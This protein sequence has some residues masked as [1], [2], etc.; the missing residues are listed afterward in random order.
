DEALQEYETILELDPGLKAA[1]NQLGYLYAERGDFATGL[2]FMD[3]YQELAADEPNPYDSRGEI[4]MFSGRFEEAVEQFK[5]ALSKRPDFMNSIKGLRQAYGELDD[6]ENAMKFADRAINSAASEYTQALT[7]VDQALLSWRFDRIL[8]AQE[9]LKKAQQ[10]FPALV[11]PALIGGEMYRSIGDRAAAQQLQRKYLNW[12]RRTKLNTEID[13]E[14]LY[15]MLHFSLEAD[16]PPEELLPVVETITAGETRGMQ[17]QLYDIYLS[18]LNIRAGN[19]SQARTY[20]KS[21]NEIFLNLLT[22]VRPSPRNDSWKYSIEA[23]R[24]LPPE[25]TP[26]YTY[27][28]Q[29]IARAQRA[30]RQDVEVMG[31]LLR[32][33][34]HEKNARLDDMAS[35]YVS[36]G[37][38]REGEWM[39]IGPFSNRGGFHKEFPPEEKIDLSASY[40]SGKRS[41]NWQTAEDGVHDGYVDL[42]AILQSSSWAVGYG[43]INIYSPDKRSVQLRLSTD[44]ACKLWV[45]G[46]LVWQVFRQGSVAFDNDIVSVI[47]HP[48]NNKVL[49]KVSNSIKDWGFY[50]RV[51]DEKG[52]GFPDIKFVSLDKNIRA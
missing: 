11:N 36:T 33:Q 14:S 34:Y 50:F 46:K 6:F 4:L 45:N 13:N 32:A 7:Y 42:G 12:F 10:L 49:L 47:L 44:E 35:E 17:R 18:T 39:V 5:I 22:R 38:P 41:L 2:A 29:L 25:K 37:L 40:R 28:D 27:F 26:D 30:D 43:A 1:Y 51:T 3:K 23:I 24:L 16:L 15:A 48:G 19:Y 31:R 20:L 52:N 21:Q 8:E 9:A